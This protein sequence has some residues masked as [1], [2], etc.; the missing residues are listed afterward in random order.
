MDD[1]PKEDTA[2][3]KNHF[4]ADRYRQIWR[5]HLLGAAMILNGNLSEFTSL[6]VFPEGNGHFREDNKNHL[7]SDYKEKLT[8]EGKST[9][10]YITYENLFLKMRKHLHFQ[11]AKEWVDYLEKRYI[12]SP[13]FK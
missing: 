3:C 7:W 8:E 4:V 12:P 9:L 11:G 13:V 10:T 6:T 1:V 2:K 5:N